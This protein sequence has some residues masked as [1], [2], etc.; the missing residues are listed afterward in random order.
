MKSVHY[1]ID[2]EG[3]S[4]PTPFRQ[5]QQA[6]GQ[7][8]AEHTL[9]AHAVERLGY[10]HVQEWPRGLII[11][12]HRPITT[13]VTLAGAIYLLS[14][15]GDRRVIFSVF[16]GHV[17]Y[18]LCRGRSQAIGRLVQQMRDLEVTVLQTA[19]TASNAGLS[20]RPMRV[21]TKRNTK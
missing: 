18:S 11:S 19:R 9:I 17:R 4:L 1:L 15:L 6:L 21:A 20:A 3:R 10:L 13:P 7:S 2:S 16:D 14:E 5:L 8:V 12:Y